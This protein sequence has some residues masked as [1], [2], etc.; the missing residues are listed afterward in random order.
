MAEEPA[1]E[2]TQGPAEE[3]AQEPV[4]L[5]RLEGDGSCVA[6]RISGATGGEGRGGGRARALVGEFVV[7]T[8]FVRGR[9][10]TWVF[11][12][13]LQ[14]WQEALDALDAGHDV[15]WR[16]GQRAPEL[17][18]ERG[19]ESVGDA[20]RCRVSVRD[21]AMSLTTVTVTVPLPDAWFDDAYRRLELVR[22]TWPLDQPG[23]HADRT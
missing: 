1:E 18:I 21:P 20:G 3:P 15:A 2:P 22:E 11:A 17:R 10:A 6:L 9:L 19:E 7:E 12:T 14:T 23:A 8:G 5:L 16:E 13:D 4:D